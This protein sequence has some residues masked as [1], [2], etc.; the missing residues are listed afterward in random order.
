MAKLR[1]QTLQKII[2][3]LPFLPLPFFPWI[4]ATRHHAKFIQKKSIEMNIQCV[5][6]GYIQL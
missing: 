6:Y 4:D 3:P 1:L 5:Y 2:I